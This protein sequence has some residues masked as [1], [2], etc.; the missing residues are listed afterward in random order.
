M[1]VPSASYGLGTVM[2][3]IVMYSCIFLYVSATYHVTVGCE[4]VVV[5]TVKYCPLEC[6]LRGLVQL[7]WTI[8]HCIPED[9]TL[10]VIQ[11]FIS[12]CLCVSFLHKQLFPSQG[13][14]NKEAEW[15]PESV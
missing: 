6:T 4:V 2:C 9:Y 1:L 5:A 13:K 3:T 12:V 10:L 15:A 8:W 7:C 11:L 14:D